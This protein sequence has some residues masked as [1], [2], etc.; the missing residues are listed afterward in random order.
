[1]LAAFFLPYLGVH[2]HA[3]LPGGCERARNGFCF[4]ALASATC[5]PAARTAATFLKGF[6]A[7]GLELH[8]A[9][10]DTFRVF[11]TIE[12]L[13]TTALFIL[14]LAKVFAILVN[15]EL[16]FF[17]AAE[18]CKRRSLIL[19]DEACF[20]ISFPGIIRIPFSEHDHRRGWVARI[21]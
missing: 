15:V 21:Q 4:A 3:T 9:H 11:E 5:N 16:T 6:V 2:L 14:N 7:C 12:V 19:E 20:D 18:F 10:H 8:L 13:G 1:M 17:V